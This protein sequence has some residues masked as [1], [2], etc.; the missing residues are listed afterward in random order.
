LE[1]DLSKPS[2]S[3]NDLAEFNSNSTNW[4]DSMAN[5]ICKLSL[6]DASKNAYESGKALVG[7]EKEL[8]QLLSFFRA[9]FREDHRSEGYKSSMFLAGPPGVVS[10]SECAISS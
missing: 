3:R 9:A 8:S 10:P 5:L 2:S 7:R 1:Q 6:K 4:K